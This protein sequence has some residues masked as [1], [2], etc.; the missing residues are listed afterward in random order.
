[1]I[2]RSRAEYP[3]NISSVPLDLSLSPSGDIVPACDPFTYMGQPF[4]VALDVR[5]RNLAGAL[6]A[7]Y[8]GDFAKGSA[9]ITVANDKDGMTLS[10]RLRS[11]QP[12]PWLDG[13]ATFTGSSE[14]VRVSDV[15]PDGPYK[16]LLFGLYMRDND[17]DRSLIAMPNFNDGVVGDCSGGSCN[18]RLI[19]TVPMQVYF[20]R[21]LAKTETGVASAALAVAQQMQYYE[22]GG[23]Q[24][25]RLDQC[26]LLSLANQGF[27]FSGAGQS[28]DTA[29]SELNIGGN[30][31]IK[32]GLGSSPP[33]GMAAVA[34]DGEILLQFGKPEMAVRIPYRVELVKQ[35]TQPLWLSDPQTLQGEAIFGS[36]RG[37]DRIIYRREV[38]H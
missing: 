32:L 19:D 31:K 6:T 11:L 33:G 1:D 17:G 28:L 5:A 13:R 36:S 27:S 24:Q 26:T 25:N 37:N 23:W 21:L 16:S 8:T 12:L 15:Q 29:S 38:M 35:P 20:G 18:A 4:G 14:F 10:S 7:N 22:A 9:F 2:Y 3:V 34:K 30:R